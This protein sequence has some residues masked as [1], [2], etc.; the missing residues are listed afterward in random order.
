MHD[1]LEEHLEASGELTKQF[2]TL[3]ASVR[4]VSHRPDE[5][6]DEFSTRIIHGGDPTALLVKLADM[7]VRH[8]MMKHH[9]ARTVVRIRS[10]R[11]SHLEDAP[12]APHL[13]RTAAQTG[14]DLAAVESSVCTRG[15]HRVR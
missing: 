15:R 14:H 3:V 6:Y 8:H 11:A 5:T 13:H 4:V 12:G 2:S 7:S 9:T 10:S 1:V